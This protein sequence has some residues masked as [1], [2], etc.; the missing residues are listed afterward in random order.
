[1]QFVKFMTSIMGRAV[2][3]VAGLVIIAI[4]LFV[5]QGTIGTIM[6]VVGLVPIAGGLFDFCLA[7]V[8]LGYPFDGEA[9]REQIAH[10]RTA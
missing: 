8:A 9:A 4:G 3:I 7:G 2:R 5:V 10:E 6:A 1:M